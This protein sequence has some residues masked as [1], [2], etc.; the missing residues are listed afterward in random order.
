MTAQAHDHSTQAAP[1]ATGSARPRWLLPALVGGI[2]VGA[3]VVF[4]V[5]SP[6]VVLYGGLIGGML[7]MHAG[8]HGGH[9]SRT[10]PDP[11][12]LS[13]RSHGSHPERSGS[14]EAPQDRASINSNR[15]E[16]ETQDHDQ[17]SSHECH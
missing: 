10:K 12:D 13:Q 15:S 9:G 7:L 11:E 3:L 17:H 2:V 5:L 4:G 8:G 1:A 6:S 16:S 14:D